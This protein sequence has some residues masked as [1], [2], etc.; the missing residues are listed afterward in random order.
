MHTHIYRTL[1]FALFV[2]L[3]SNLVPA[4]ALAQQLTLKE[5]FAAGQAFEQDFVLTAYYSPEPDQCCYVKGNLIADAILNGQGTH[6]ADGT[7]VYPGMLAAPGSYP[8]GTRIVL[9]GLGTFTVHDRGGAIQEWSSAHR[10]DVWAGAGEEGLARALHFG[11]KKMK[12][13]VYPPGSDQPAVSVDL[14]KLPAPPERLRPFQ[15]A[16]TG[17]FGLKGS[18]GQTSL[19]VSLVQ[20]ALR[21]IGYFQEAVT[22]FY[23][24]ATVAALA[25]FQRDFRLEGSAEAFSERTLAVLEARRRRVRAQSPIPDAVSPESPAR[26][27]VQ[28]QRALRFIGYYRG[29][30][31]G[32]FSDTLRNAILTLQQ[33]AGL[34]AD[35]S[36]PGAGRIGPKT[37]EAI[38]RVWHRQLAHAG[39]DRLQAYERV[40]ST[41]RERGLGTFGFLSKGDKG[42][43]VKSV[44]Q[45]LVHLGFLPAE[46]A[47]GLYGDMTEQAILA[48]QKSHG[49]IQSE[50][51]QGAGS[52]G[53]ATVMRLRQ[54][55]V[56]R[57]YKLVRSYGWEAL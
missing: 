32:V 26:D 52:V 19:S 21:D 15:V 44:Q 56:D 13:T 28:A 27:I 8:F 23:G 9:P 55:E 20:E 53:P 24:P 10:L 47:T 42:S 22:G 40:Q 33:R 30:T 25:A 50:T 2:C 4:S 57:L 14:T 11:V 34:V 6:A 45:V 48:F 36:S 38:L 41:M 46:K 49:V 37:K 5:K 39:A 12:G 51:D 43:A 1:C 16:G 54:I 17:V 31:D 18:V 3:L 29:R 7:P 35:A